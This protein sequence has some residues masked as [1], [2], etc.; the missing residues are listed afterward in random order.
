MEYGQEE[1][2]LRVLD[3]LNF[4]M[5]RGDTVA[6]VGPSG[7]GKTTILQLLAALEQPTKGK[8]ELDSQTLSALSPDEL[9]DFRRDNMG[10]VFQSFHL[11]D[12]L[13]ALANAA[14][15]LDIAGKPNATH[16]AKT[17]LDRVGLKDRIQH[18]PQQ[19]SGGEQQR[20]AIARALMGGDV[21]IQSSEPINQE[22]LDWI[23]NTGDISLT[24]ELATMMSTE[25]DEFALV[26][27]LSAD[28]AYPLYGELKLQLLQTLEYRRHHH[29]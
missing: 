5:E 11:I 15:P 13:S 17:M 9:A 3:N 20:V 28:A 7:S 26:E 4:N 24:R 23:A 22:A 16:L 1:A 18:Y 27:L 29:C 2:P 19:L 8:I 6:I 14:L 25:D 10:I 12:S 21:E